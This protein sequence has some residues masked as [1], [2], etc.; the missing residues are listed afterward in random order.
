MNIYLP[1]KQRNKPTFYLFVILFII[2]ITINIFNI[3][4][5]LH[6]NGFYSKILLLITIIIILIIRYLLRLVKSTRKAEYADYLGKRV[7]EAIQGKE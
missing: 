3:S 6:C 1:V 5:T 7:S 2:N 4:L